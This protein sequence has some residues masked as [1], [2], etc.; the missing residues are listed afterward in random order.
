MDNDL[1]KP[2]N[3]K[4]YRWLLSP[5]EFFV[6][7]RDGSASLAQRSGLGLLFLGNSEGAI[8]AQGAGIIGNCLLALKGIYF[9]NQ[10]IHGSRW[11]ELW[12]LQEDPIG[13]FD[14]IGVSIPV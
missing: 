4:N 9:G 8:S 3:S 1:P 14:A 13:L 2:V 12:S 11:K 10:E 6:I 5:T 7:I